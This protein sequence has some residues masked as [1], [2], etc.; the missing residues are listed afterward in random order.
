MSGTGGN[1]AT[2]Y[3]EVRMRGDWMKFL[4][5]KHGVE[6]APF[7]P[8]SDEAKK[9]LEKYGIEEVKTNESTEGAVPAK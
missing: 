1:T 7:I 9:L 2:L 5:E 3:R 4:A 8:L 6:E